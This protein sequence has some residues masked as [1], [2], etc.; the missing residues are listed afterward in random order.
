MNGEAG[1][2]HRALRV[3]I[4]Q[5]LGAE[6]RLTAA[7]D[8]SCGGITALFGPSGSGKTTILDTI[9]GLRPDVTR[10][11]VHIGEEPWQD[12]Q[13]FLPAW[14]RRVGYVF[15]DARLLPDRD[16]S[17]NLDYAERRAPPGGPDRSAVVSWLGIEA[18]LRRAPDTLSAGEQQ[19]VAIARALLRNPRLLLLDEPLSNLDAAAAATCMGALLHAQRETQ[20]PMLYV[21]HKLEEIHTLADQVI[22]LKRGEIVA[23]GPL[24]DLASNLESGLVDNEA[25][26]AIVAIEAAE[27]AVED[28]LQAISLDGQTLW[29]SAHPTGRNPNR[30]RVPARDVSV[31]RERPRATSILNVLEVTLDG[32]RDSS[33][34]HCLLRLR[35]RSQHLLARITQRSRRELALQPGDRLF[36]QVKSTALLG[37]RSA[38]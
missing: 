31:C 3:E 19:R 26:A 12:G 34:A 9:A 33:D 7:F 23:R 37:D 2:E 20:W 18:L 4:D 22:V 32:I 38:Q 14:D 17:A 24:L 15:Q 11:A 13:T 35:L 25:A 10:A 1:L 27:P 36:A 21:S 8:L 16:V 29:V 28:G 30:L 5:S 6:F